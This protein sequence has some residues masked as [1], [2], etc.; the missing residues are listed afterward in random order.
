M[1]TP[2][3]SV[4]PARNRSGLPQGHP[5]ASLRIDQ[6]FRCLVLLPALLLAGCAGIG[7]QRS[8]P[9]PIVEPVRLPEPAPAV[10]PQPAATESMPTPTITP[11]PS[12][13]PPLLEES[14]PSES[15][16]REI[17][18]GYSSSPYGVNPI[19]E[20]LPPVETAEPV[21][22]GP[23]EDA[24]PPAAA[25]PVWPSAASEPV[26][27]AL[28]P[29]PAPRLF[30]MN[31]PPAVVAL[32]GDIESQFRSGGYADA[33]ASLERAIRIQPKNPELWHVLADVR[34]RQQQPGLAE[35]LA[36]KS[37]LLAR[38]NAE[39]VR[40]NWRIIGEAC[41]LKGDASCAAEAMDKARY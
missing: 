32:Q 5:A 38:N 41:R 18:P 30:A 25:E 17:L 3:P 13:R 8:A 4:S 29:P 11:L 40:G 6:R 9:A 36:R 33:A 28:T 37:N 16:P 27:P 21:P 22:Y 26:S 10:T 31:A 23:P 39:L 14:L 35:D 24:T 20:S 34:L 15:A 19:P 12:S 2:V 7:G 1:I